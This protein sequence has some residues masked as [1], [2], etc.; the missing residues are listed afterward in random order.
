MPPRAL[1]AYLITACKRKAFGST[2]QRL[3]RERQV[4]DHAEEVAGSGDRAVLASCSEHAVRCAHGPEWGE[5]PLPPVRERLVSVFDEGI[6]GD[7]RELLSWVAQHISYSEIAGW[8][9]A[10]RTTVVKRVTRLRARLIDATIRYGDN[11]EREERRELLRFLRRS[12]AFTEK[13]LEP[14]VRRDTGRDHVKTPMK[15][16]RSDAQQ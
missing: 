10:K 4:S 3:V 1:T 13:D 15:E 6:S 5:A 7:E 11:L 2:R 8:V 9:G 12:G 16:E 14:L